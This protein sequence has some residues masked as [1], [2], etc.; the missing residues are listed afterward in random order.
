[1]A[2]CSRA[3]VRKPKNAKD[4]R[5]LIENAIPKSR[6]VVPKWSVKIFLEWQNGMKN[7]NPVIEACAFTTGS[8]KVLCLDT[9]IANM[10]A[11]SLNY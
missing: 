5:N 8:S 3:S 2:S 4:E 11:E 9:D 10:T 7:K 6:R 1:M